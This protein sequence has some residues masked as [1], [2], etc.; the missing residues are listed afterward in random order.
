MIGYHKEIGGTIYF[1]VL[2]EFD[3]ESNS[4]S[5]AIRHVWPQRD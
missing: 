2:P 3:H 4:D 1:E 5:T